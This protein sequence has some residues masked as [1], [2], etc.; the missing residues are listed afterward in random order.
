MFKK[1]YYYT[2]R[3]YHEDGNISDGWRVGDTHPLL[4]QENVEKL[5]NNTVR[6]TWWT[7]ID[8]KIAQN[9]FKQKL[10]NS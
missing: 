10:K 8:E 1:Y 5:I 7:E 6:I 9:I 2:V 4:I 3:T